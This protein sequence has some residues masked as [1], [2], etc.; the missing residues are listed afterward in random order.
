MTLLGPKVD[1]AAQPA[2]TKLSHRLHRTLRRVS[3]LLAGLWHHPITQCRHQQYRIDSAG[4]G[5]HCVHE[6][7]VARHIDETK[8][9]GSGISKVDGDATFFLCQPIGVD[10]GDRFRQ[11]GLAVVSMAG[12]ADDY[13]A[14]ECAQCGSAQEPWT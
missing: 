2:P 1:I 9:I 5:E 6:T 10:T 3:V 13:A 4:A 7:L 11:C 12:G 14:V 8:R